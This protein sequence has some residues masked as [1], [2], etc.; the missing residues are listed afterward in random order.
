MAKGN[1]AKSQVQAPPSQFSFFQL[2]LFIL[3]TTSLALNISIIYGL[4]PIKGK[5]KFSTDDFRGLV[6]GVWICGIA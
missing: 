6:I 1:K 4:I 3:A 2:V 5:L